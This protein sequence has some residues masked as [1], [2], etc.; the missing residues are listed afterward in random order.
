MNRVT[1]ECSW[2]FVH[3][4]MA[5][6]LLSTCFLFTPFVPA[7]KVS[8]SGTTYYVSSSTGSDS[9][10]G[11]S[12]STPWQ[13]IAKLNSITFQAGDIICLKAGDTW[14]DCFVAHG[15]GTE[16]TPITLTS[17]GTG[18]RPR[19]ARNNHAEGEWCINLTN[20]EGW[21]ITNLELSDA[22]EGI[23]MRV[24]PG[25]SVEYF[26][27]EN[28]YFHDFTKTYYGYWQDDVSMH[29]AAGVYVYTRGTENP[30][31]VI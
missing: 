3:I 11:T 16:V 22:A 6:L 30:K 2:D 23:I 4:K 9:N 26:W 24:L 13:T 27:I 18:R 19:I 7:N 31:I 8:A 25:N 29:F 17:Y 21:K 20:I 15:S 1:L 5:V 10:N 12:S 14:N 28:C